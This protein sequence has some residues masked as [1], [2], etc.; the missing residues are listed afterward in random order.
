MVHESAALLVQ[1]IRQSWGVDWPYNTAAAITSHLYNV[2]DSGPVLL[3]NW[4]DASLAFLDNNPPPHASA[5]QQAAGIP[6]GQPTKAAFLSYLDARRRDPLETLGNDLGPSENFRAFRSCGYI[7]TCV[8]SCA[9]D[10]PYLKAAALAPLPQCVLLQK[11]DGIDPD[12]GE[13]IFFQI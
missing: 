2:M 10:L 8:R 5:Q 11:S 6:P 9:N 3:L 12:V 7:S 13:V 4:N 1:N